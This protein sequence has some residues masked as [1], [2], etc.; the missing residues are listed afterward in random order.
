MSII[1]QLVEGQ[2]APLVLELGPQSAMVVLDVRS[3]EVLAVVGSYEGVAHGLNRAT[4]ARRQPGSTFKALTYSYGL[5]SKQYTAASVFEVKHRGHGVPLEGLP[6]ISLRESLAHSNNEVAVEVF[7]RLGPTAVVNWAKQFGIESKLEPDL[8]LA[9]GA[10]EVTPMEMA[11]AY[12]TFARGGVWT[13]PRMIREIEFPDGES[14][15]QPSVR[16]DVEVLSSEESYLTTSLLQ[17][18]I[19]RGTGS[20]ALSLRRPLAGKTGT[21][22]Q[23]KDAWFIGYSPELLC[24]V[25]V[26]Y[27]D[28]KPLG[29]SESGAK[30]A[31]P[32]WIEFMQKA[33]EGRPVTDFP[34]PGGLISVAVDPASGLLARDGENSVEELFIV[35]T[36][37]TELSPLVEEEIDEDGVTSPDD[38]RT[39][40]VS[41]ENSAQEEGEG[42]PEVK[43][44]E[45]LIPASEDEENGS[46]EAASEA[47]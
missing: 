4:N 42:M 10:Y 23:S 8:S 26:G 12:A 29:K 40:G 3:A 7:K 25:W 18:V 6:I 44:P 16:D 45:P 47:P 33:H 24:A 15:P 22:N 32:A 27:D 14:G 13:A 17:S 31:Q 21:T 1:E 34:R 46:G 38:P 11:G 19:S 9:L 43:A 41:A 30:T 35:G 28:A 36:E 20:A 37:P 5:H 2:V 39:A